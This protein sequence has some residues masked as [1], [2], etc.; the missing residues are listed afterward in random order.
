MANEQAL[1][2]EDEVHP[3]LPRPI[4]APSAP[5][6]EVQVT[7]ATE[8]PVKKARAPKKPAPVDTLVGASPVK[9]AA[10]ATFKTQLDDAQQIRADAKQLPKALA[11]IEKLSANIL[12]LTGK[13]TALKA[14]AATTKDLLKTTKLDAAKLLKTSIDAAGMKLA[15]KHLLREQAAYKDGYKQGSAAAARAVNAA[16]KGV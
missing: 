16:L 2:W 11:Q 4:T 13:I 9:V 6:K 7:T 10:P 5:I 14:D 1:P 3:E 15:E 8:A 12:A